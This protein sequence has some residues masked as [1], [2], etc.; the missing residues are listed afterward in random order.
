MEEAGSKFGSVINDLKSSS[1][2]LLGREEEKEEERT[3]LNDLEEA[4]CG[5]CPSLGYKQR[6]MGFCACLAFGLFLTMGSMFRI[7]QAVTGRPLPFVIYYTLGN[8]VSICGSF[9]LYGPTKQV[10]QMFDSKRFWATSCYLASLVACLVVAFAFH[11]IGRGLVLL[12]LVA[13]QF[14]SMV[15][16]SLTYVP[17]ARKI[18][19][20][21]AQEL[22]C[23]DSG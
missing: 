14:V 3:A 6:M 17:F 21:M 10:K 7:M 19:D 22:C 5:L 2:R 16:Y 23:R 4:V 11:F 8:V 18:A 12:L 13:V 1:L 20:R 9:F 15:Y